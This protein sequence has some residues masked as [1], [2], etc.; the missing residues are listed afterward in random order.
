[1]EKLP[2]LLGHLKS[3]KFGGLLQYVQH[4]TNDGVYDT[5]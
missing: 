4:L 2:A 5:A 1:M 3:A